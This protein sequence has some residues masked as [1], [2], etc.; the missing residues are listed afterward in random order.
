[1]SYDIEA[2]CPKCKST[3]EFEEPHHMIGGTYA[4]GGSTEA[5]L[6]VTYNYANRFDFRGLGGRE[7]AKTIPELEAAVKRLGTERSAD[8]WENTEGNAGAACANLLTLA[9][10]AVREEADA[11]WSVT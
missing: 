11:I 3:I 1:M 7:V 10:A 5:W 6:N 8:Y 2:V 4:V 9:E